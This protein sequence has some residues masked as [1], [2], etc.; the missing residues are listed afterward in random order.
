MCRQRRNLHLHHLAYQLMC[1][2][3]HNLH[4]YHLAP[5]FPLHHSHR[6]VNLRKLCQPNQL[7]RCR[8]HQVHYVPRSHPGPLRGTN[9]DSLR[10]HQN[11]RPPDHPIECLQDS[12]EGIEKSLDN[13]TLSRIRSN[14]TRPLHRRETSIPL[15]VSITT[16]ISSFFI[17]T[18]TH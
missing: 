12:L 14:S 5:P 6:L 17:Y 13:S 7:P 8:E 15:F 11:S 9:F 3:R 1:R 4:L 18:H 10:G 2:Q 16:D